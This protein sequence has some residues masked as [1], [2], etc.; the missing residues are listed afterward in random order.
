MKK[1][2]YQ[3]R[4][5]TDNMFRRLPT[6][7]RKFGRIFSAENLVLIGELKLALQKMEVTVFSI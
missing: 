1:S 2:I 6:E 3:R 7:K 4:N 5:I